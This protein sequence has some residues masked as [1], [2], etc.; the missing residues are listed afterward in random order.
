MR[1]LA[2]AVFFFLVGCSSSSPGS[3]STTQQHTGDT[4]PACTWPAGADTFEDASST[5]CKPRSVFQICEVPSGSTIEA[6]GAIESPDGAAAQ[7]S[8]AC[9]AT[10]YELSCEGSTDGGPGGAIPQPDPSLGC[11]VIPIPTPS[12]ALFY[13]CPCGS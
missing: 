10:E 4:I 9:T 2:A 11:T 3:S 5:G 8:D 1:N 13:C 6:D 7:C 12:N